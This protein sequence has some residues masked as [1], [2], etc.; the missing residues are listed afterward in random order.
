[1]AKKK[2]KIIED[3][4]NFV[5]DYTPV[6]KE[7]ACKIADAIL[8][9]LIAEQKAKEKENKTEKPPRKDENFEYDYT[10]V[11]PYVFD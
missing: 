11:K 6:N 5:Y 2:K 3:D 10:P 7:K 9:V 1:M 8:D 4:E